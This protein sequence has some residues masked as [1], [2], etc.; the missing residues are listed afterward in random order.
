MLDVTAVLP[1]TVRSGAKRALRAYGVATSGGRVLPDFLIIGAKRGGTT[2]LWRYLEQH[3]LLAPP[4]PAQARFKGAHFFDTRYS[5]GL[6][7]YRSH[8]PTAIQRRLLEQK[9]GAPTVV[10]EASPYYLFHPCSAERAAAVLPGAKLVLV[11]RNPVDRAYSHFKARRRDGTETLPFEDAID[12]EGERLAGEESRLRTQPGYSSFAHE[13]Y[14]YIT[15]GLYLAPL[16]VWL[17]HYAPEQVLIERSE[18]L[19]AQP[20]AVYDR[21]LKFLLLPPLRLRTFGTFNSTPADPMRE[22]TRAA[23]LERVAPQNRDLER[24]LGRELHWDT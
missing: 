13:H 6:A 20:Q 10:G 16:L 4:F 14:S 5:A 18:D 19:Y 8:F 17:Q 21:V 24:F 22:R 9:L 2:S 1:P 12:A 7:W 15:Q 3:P 23:L 11:L